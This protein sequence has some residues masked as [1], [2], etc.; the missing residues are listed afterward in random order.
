MTDALQF[1]AAPFFMCLILVGIHCYLGLH[2]LARGVI[3]VDLALAQV[4]ALGTTTAYLV[5]F[6]HHDFQAYLFALT[7]TILAAGYLAIANRYK[8]RVSQ[9]A[10]IGVLYAFA[11]AGVVL[12]IDRMSH[13]AEHLKYILSGQLLWVTWGDLGRTL[14]I[15][16]PVSLVHLIFRRKLLE[17]SFSGGGSVIWDFLFYALFA[18]VITSSV[19]IAGVLLVFAFLV[20]PAI[21]SSL[22]FESIL[23]RLV[24]GWI[25]GLVLSVVGLAASY[26]WDLPSGSTLVLLFTLPA[27]ACIVLLPRPE[28]N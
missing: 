18:F 4:A 21:I 24:F 7:F 12:L 25:I 17:A 3:F 22:F 28:Q 14:L 10:L 19:H 27:L 1:L 16:V 9:E 26:V 23:K 13:G 20:V 15:Y 5:G 6:D 2:V 8:R 11:S